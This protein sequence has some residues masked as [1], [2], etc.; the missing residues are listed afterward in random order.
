VRKA[1][2]GLAGEGALRQRH[3]SGTF[4]ARPGTRVQQALS[5]LNSFTEDMQIRG[6]KPS[7]QWLERSIGRATSDEAMQLGLSPGE[8]VSRLFR[9][10]LADG[11]PMAV[12]RAVVPNRLLP[13]PETVGTSLYEALDR[14]GHRPVR[15]LQRMSAEALDGEDAGLLALPVGAAVLAAERLSFLR[16]GEMVEFT[17][18]HYRGDTYDF[19]AELNL[20]DGT[21]P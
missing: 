16:S 13:E 3:G 1:I 21:T 15:A 7:S 14:L 5:R 17:R 12:E 9:L 2:Q 18:S 11:K 19:V 20:S 8:K 6:L 4:V 10:R